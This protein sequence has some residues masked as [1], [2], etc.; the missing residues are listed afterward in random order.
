MDASCFSKTSKFF[1]T[2]FF[3]IRCLFGY[4]FGCLFVSETER[5]LAHCL[6]N[7]KLCSTILHLLRLLAWLLTC[8]TINK[9]TDK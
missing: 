4:L 9:I 2:V 6:A 7:S 1:V 5:V 8:K 3:K